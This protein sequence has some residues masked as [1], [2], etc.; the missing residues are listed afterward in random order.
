VA[1]PRVW[2]DTDVAL[3][4]ARGDVDDGFALAAL[5]CAARQGRI[6]MLGVST[7]FGNATAQISASCAQQIAAR[8]GVSVRIVRGAEEP[9]RDSE[10]AEA[11]AGLPPG[12]E[13][14]CIG[15]L[16]NAAAACRRDPTLPRR[17]SLRAVGG[18]LT[19][20]GFLPP[21]WPFEF[22]FSCDRESARYVLPRDWQR[23]TLYPLDVVCDLKVGRDEL[24][25]IAQISSL[26]AFLARESH[27]WLVR[28]RW[29]HLDRRFP[30]W[31][32]SAALDVMGSLSAAHEVRR[33]AFGSRLLLGVRREFLC[34]AD[35]GANEAWDSFSRLL[36]D[37]VTKSCEEAR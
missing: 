28:S 3:G 31:D 25:K 37:G 5:F 12:A 36:A 22:N 23:L 16:T 17:V 24:A 10:A 21:V 34:L 15:P 18:N 9:G 27:R 29:R 14:L 2:V 13:L 26:G 4:S 7:V 30:L 1:T 19:S 20:H 35:L 11:L 33:L 6:E 8:A 32:L